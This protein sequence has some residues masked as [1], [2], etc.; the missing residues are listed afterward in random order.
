MPGSG[1]G[2][3]GR[4]ARIIASMETIGADQLAAGHHTPGMDRR[5]A[6]AHEGT[7]V[8]AVT[9]EPGTASG[10]H[11]HGAHSSYLYIES[12]RARFETR[13]G[14]AL[15]CRSGD[16]VFIPPEEVH[17]EVNPGDEPSVVVL[18]RV[19]SGEVVVNV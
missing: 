12:G 3:E 10:W 17:R 7:W 2:A 1:A 4:K 15:D 16:F 6:F 8:G 18:F 5:Q 11:H 14:R 9:M 13:E 19:G